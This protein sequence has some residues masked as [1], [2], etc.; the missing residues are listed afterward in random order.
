[1][2]PVPAPPEIDVAETADL[3]RMDNLTRKRISSPREVCVGTT[4]PGGIGGGGFVEGAVGPYEYVVIEND[5]PD[6]LVAWLRDNGYQVPEAA[7]PIIAAYVEEGMMFLAM[8]LAPDAETSDIQ[9]VKLTMPMDAPMIPIR[10]ASVASV[11]LLPIYVWIF[12]E[13][14]YAPVNWAHPTLDF[15][16]LRGP[17]RWRFAVEPSMGG[18]GQ[19]P[20]VGYNAL[21]DAALAAHDGRAFVTEYAM[22]T[23]N[24]DP[25]DNAL[26]S[27]F[28]ARFPYVT[29]LYGEI[30]PEQMTLDPAFAPAPDLPDV[31]SELNAG[32]FV[33]PLVYY[34]CSTRELADPTLPADLLA[35]L[36]YTVL[37]D[38]STTYGYYESVTQIVPHPAGWTMSQVSL[39]LAS[40]EG[41][42]P[43]YIFAPEAVTADDVAAAFAGDP[44][45][46]MLLIADSGSAVASYAYEG[47]FNA[48]GSELFDYLPGRGDA[49]ADGVSFTDGGYAEPPFYQLRRRTVRY[50][51]LTTQDDD[52]ANGAL[53][54]AAASQLRNFQHYLSPELPHTLFVGLVD[55]TYG[56]FE[57]QSDTFGYLVAYP[58]GWVE[59]SDLNSAPPQAPTLPEGSAPGVLREA[60]NF[61]ESAVVAIIAPETPTEGDPEARLVPLPGMIRL[62]GSQYEE[63]PQ[64]ALDWLDNIAESYGVSNEPLRAAVEGMSFCNPYVS[65]LIP[66]ERDGRRGYFRVDQG[67]GNIPYA[68]EVTADAARFD[69][70]EATLVAIAESF[71]TTL[72]PICG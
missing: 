40:G 45:V 69:D 63:T 36:D 56:Y 71:T 28:A 33:D 9:P 19:R 64:E 48:L 70:H 18:F 16:A 10:I 29:R 61:T 52:A 59:R 43:V 38:Y 11:D 4:P 46:P 3:D 24:L 49:L 67:T 54:E 51:W 55:G 12:G 53:Y 68:I 7:E 62:L 72:R 41:D 58:A 66:F 2:L 39:P 21:V 60:V 8:K 22:P 1:V 14:Q 32:D 30:A 35:A 57:T 27:D 65:P 23:S 20:R 5:S 15:G 42:L 50:A 37:P 34:G 26:I 31:S 47:F 17:E 13:S 25:G 44:R 6:E